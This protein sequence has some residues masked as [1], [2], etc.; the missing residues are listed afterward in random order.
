MADFTLEPRHLLIVGM[1]GSG[2]T[3]FVNR[4]LL[5]DEAV[6][7]RFI[8]DD[9]NRM[10]PRLKLTPCYTAAQ[11]QSSLET[12]W[13]A[14]VSSRLLFSF[15][16]DTKLVFRWWLKWVWQCAQS[17]PGRKIVVIPEV[18]R[19]CNP[20]TI[21]VELALLAQAGRELGVELICDTQKPELLNGSLVGAATELVC[22]RQVSAEALRSTE[23]ALAN[24]GNSHDPAALR[25]LPP[26]AFIG[27]NRISG[28]SLPGRVF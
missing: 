20:D 13:S 17:G 16:G 4:L 11:L 3:T 24:S 23:K 19:H 6:A 15:N 28:A 2:K 26:G 10:W 14:F 27:F 1:T 22:F 25:T 12:R 8:Y 21:P 18:W 7:C 5:N 9:L